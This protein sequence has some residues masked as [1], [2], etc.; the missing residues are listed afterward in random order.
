M[1]LVSA[2]RKRDRRRRLGSLA[3]DGDLAVALGDDR[4]IVNALQLVPGD[5]A[6]QIIAGFETFPDIRARPEE[7]QLRY[8]R[9]P[10]EHVVLRTHGATSGL[11][12][13]LAHRLYQRIGE[14]VDGFEVGLLGSEGLSNGKLE[15]Y[16]GRGVFVP[17]KGRQQVADLEFS[18]VD[19]GAAEG[20]AP[21]VARFAGVESALAGQPAAW[22]EGQLGVVIGFGP[23]LAPAELPIEALDPKLGE[24][25]RGARL[26]LGKLDPCQPPVI[27]LLPAPDRAPPAFR[28]PNQT[29]WFLRDGEWQTL[30]IGARKL[31][32]RLSNRT[33]RARF[34]TRVG[35]AEAR[36]RR[37]AA[38]PDGPGGSP[39][40][41]VDGLIMP[42]SRSF[43]LLDPRAVRGWQVDFDTEGR[44]RHAE[45]MVRAFTVEARGFW[46]FGVFQ[47]QDLAYVDDRASVTG[48]KSLPLQGGAR[49]GLHRLSPS[50][51]L[52][53][54]KNAEYRA[55][56]RIYGRDSVVLAVTEK[57]GSAMRPLGAFQFNP[58]EEVAVGSG[59]VLAWPLEVARRAADPE[60]EAGE[61]AGD[62]SFDWVN[63]SARVESAGWRGLARFWLDAWDLKMRA[64][65]T[66]LD[67][68]AISRER[69]G[70]ELNYSIPVR[71]FGALGPLWVQYR[72][73]EAAGDVP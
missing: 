69:A 8:K 13:M 40:V 33:G 25:L 61:G 70:Q 64:H 2:F 22:Y 1:G 19:P 3:E 57:G 31:W 7:G 48:E 16:F 68:W 29:D 53:G 67:I 72:W 60:A 65:R 18:G 11:G 58:D 6:D 23:G 27:R 66:H 35:L 56:V 37:F 62:L 46:R 32:F 51:F 54:R 15:C 55:L 26:F 45:P 43:S 50:Y 71:S 5:F 47:H 73:V 28:A 38:D 4:L 9:V 30:D 14:H 52:G 41:E 17:S 12:G 36:A 10:F 34:T 20:P 42:R 44:L 21:M 24:A 49:V 39:L 59:P 63:R